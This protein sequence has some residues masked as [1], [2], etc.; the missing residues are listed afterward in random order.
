MTFMLTSKVMSPL[1]ALLDMSARQRTDVSSRPEL[2]A[3][4]PAAPRTGPQLLAVSAISAKGKSKNHRV[5]L[6]SS[7]RLALL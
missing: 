5:L 7:F 1:N 6:D 3:H 2:P 4:V